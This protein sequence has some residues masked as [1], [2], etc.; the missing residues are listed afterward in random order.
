MTDSPTAVEEL[1]RADRFSD[2]Q[3]TEACG[4][5]IDDLRRLIT[6]KAV[7]PAQAGGG[8]GRRRLW[9][10]GHVR[11]ISVTAALYHAGFSLR[12]A[13][14]IGYCMPADPKLLPTQP[15]YFENP[16]EF[17]QDLLDPAN[18]NVEPWR[19]GATV[20]VIN[21]QYL[22]QGGRKVS[23]F[24]VLNEARTELLGN[25]P[26]EAAHTVPDRLRTNRDGTHPKRSYAKWE[27][28]LGHADALEPSSLAYRYSEALDEKHALKLR[29]NPSDH[30][31]IYLTLPLQIAYRKVLGLPV[32]YP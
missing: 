9:T 22:F 14:T 24:G 10:M 7:I 13:H 6:W 18:R 3:V 4:I 30:Q 15:N 29:G 25:V 2:E 27:N 12:M 16:P 1:L 8:R 23:F 20:E 5:G 17:V 32:D 31:T 26:I 21:G 11:R 28:Q 19:Y